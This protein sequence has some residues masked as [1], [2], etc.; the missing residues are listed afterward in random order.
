LLFLGQIE[1]GVISVLKC[2]SPWGTPGCIRTTVSVCRLKCTLRY[3]YFNG[4]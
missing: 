4:P 3:L 2:R 1:L